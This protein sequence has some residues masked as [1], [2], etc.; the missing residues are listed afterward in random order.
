ME[1]SVFRTLEPAPTSSFPSNIIS[2]TMVQ[3]RECFF[4]WEAVGKVLTLG[5]LQKSGRSLANRC[6]L[7]QKTEE[8]IEHVCSIVKK[9]RV[10]WEL[11]FSFLLE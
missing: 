5:Q 9:T 1:K 3:P 10:L 4:A 7:F 8:T 6:F 11:L 2:H